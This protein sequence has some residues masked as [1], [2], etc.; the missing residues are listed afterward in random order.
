MVVKNAEEASEIVR[1]FLLKMG[2]STFISP[3]KAERTD[4]VWVVEFAVGLQAMRFKVDAEA[5]QV[6]S[7]E[8]L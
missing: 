6:L 8:T 5:A 3:R 1:S 2:W 7:Y 4:N